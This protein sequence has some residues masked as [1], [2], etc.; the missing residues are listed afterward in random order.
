MITTYIT[1]VTDIASE[2]HGKECSR[3]RPWVTRD[4][5]DLFDERRDL[6][7]RQYKEERVKEYRKTYKMVKKAL[8]KAKEAWI[9]TQC[10]EILPEQN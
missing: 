3:K 7:K 4:V 1:A 5:F 8:K 10:K 2:I 6:K 9:H